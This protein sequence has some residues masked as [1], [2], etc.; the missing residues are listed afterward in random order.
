MNLILD[1]LKEIISTVLP[2]TL[3]V[4]LINFTLVSMGF[5]V[6]ARFLIGTVLVIIG[7]TLF[8]IGVDIGIT[9]FGDQVGEALTKSN[10]LWIVLLGGLILGFFISIAEPGL[11]VLG[12][13]VENVTAGDISAT[14]LFIVV[15]F[16]LAIMISAGFVRVFFNIQLKTIL[17]LI[18]G[19]IFALAIFTSDE[20]LGIAFDASGAT[21]GVL[22]VPFILALSKGIS[23]LKKD[24]VAS[25]E[26]SFG[27]VALAS[28]GAI[29]GV[30]LLD[31]FTDQK[32]FSSDLA[33][34]TT[35]TNAIFQPFIDLFPSQVSEAITSLLPLLVIYILLQ[36]FVFK[37]DK[38]DNRQIITGFGFTFVGLI[39]FLWGVNGGFFEVGVLIGQGLV[40]KDSSLWLVAVAFLIGLVTILA[41]P[42]VFVLTRQIEDVTS[43]YVKKNVVSI[44]L[45]I[46]V[47]LA[48][49]F[50]VIR[51][52][53]PDLKLWY[54]L[55]PGYIIALGLMKWTPNLFIGIAFDAGGTATGPMTATFILAFIQGAANANPQASLLTE[56]FGMISLV[57]MAP[58]V[59]LQ[60]LGLLFKAKSSKAKEAVNE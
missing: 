54:I 44:F 39:I 21:T 37:L 51:I 59:A 22:A 10:K 6:L 55:L 46:G 60:I 28:S 41:E 53:N 30:M 34:E 18:Y 16:G 25:E 9:P 47:G 13:Q 23:K 56:G 50:S 17:L 3:I 27:L 11:L 26:D 42:A 52:I 8:L 7:L 5:P 14:S 20:F 2:I 29:I 38:R 58:I 1:K 45:S 48:V 49:A 43:G 33:L 40:S 19:V 35:S 12:S 36:I 32:S 4:L 15:S 31:I 57:A 24:S